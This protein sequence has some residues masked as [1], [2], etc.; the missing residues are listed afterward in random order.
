MKSRLQWMGLLSGLLLAVVVNAQD[1]FVP[2]GAEALGLERIT[3]DRIVDDHAGNLSNWEPYTS[4]LGNEAFLIES[5]TYALT[6][7]GEVDPFEQ[8][9][10]Y[11]VAI[12]PIDERE[13]VLGEGFFA[14]DG[15]PYLEKIN[16]YRQ[17]GN[18]GRVAGDKR[19]GAVNFITG[20]EAN[21]N[22]F[23]A[24]CVT[25]PTSRA[26]LGM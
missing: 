19:P 15:T 21:P 22:E 13:G 1:S 14:D 24:T 6:E 2:E 7:D 4:V 17:D 26:S 16:S 10:R 11:A 5:N 18:P 25:V 8:N 9:Q 3:A 12:Q 23:E 20:G